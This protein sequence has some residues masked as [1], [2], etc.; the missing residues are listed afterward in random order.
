MDEIEALF[1]NTWIKK[2]PWWIR[3]CLLFVRSQYTACEDVECRVDLEAKHFQGK[4]YII[5]L[6]VTD[7]T[8]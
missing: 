6:T 4:T 8:N 3:V 1:K 7:L 2:T 5:A